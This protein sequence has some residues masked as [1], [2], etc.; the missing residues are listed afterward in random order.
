MGGTPAPSSK[1]HQLPCPPRR[2]CT[3]PSIVGQASC[4]CLAMHRLCVRLGIATGQ[5]A[6]G[7]AHGLK[8]N[9][10]NKEECVTLQIPRGLWSSQT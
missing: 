3:Q 10:R 4:T 7:S 1:L 2:P 5:M 9:V 8:G 6:G